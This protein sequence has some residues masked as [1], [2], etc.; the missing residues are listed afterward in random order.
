[1]WIISENNTELRIINK[2]KD[3]IQEKMLDQR[4]EFLQVKAQMKELQDKISV[5]GFNTSRQNLR[6]P[7]EDMPN[8]NFNM[9]LQDFST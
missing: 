9:T 8:N 2:E 7:E 3:N 1:M 6:I 4:L 5:Q